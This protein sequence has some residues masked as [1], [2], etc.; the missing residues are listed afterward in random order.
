MALPPSWASD[1]PLQVSAACSAFPPPLQSLMLSSRKTQPS[2]NLQTNQRH[3]FAL[4]WLGGHHGAVAVGQPVEGSD[5]NTQPEARAELPK[6][7]RPRTPSSR[8]CPL[9]S[10]RWLLSSSLVTGTRPPPWTRVASRGSTE[11]SPL[12]PGALVSTGAPW[13]AARGS[14]LRKSQTTACT[15]SADTS[16]II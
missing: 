10:E 9:L 8:R 2:E 11:Q 15:L 6:L 5:P 16:G 1:L 4:L 7:L 12:S 14:F 3:A 13:G